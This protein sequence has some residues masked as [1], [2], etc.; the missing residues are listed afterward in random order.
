MSDTSDH[1]HTRYA[2]SPGARAGSGDAGTPTGR[3][4]L[5]SVDFD[6][7]AGFGDEAPAA[8]A[9]FIDL[10]QGADAAAA[11]AAVG[12]EDFLDL[13]GEAAAAHAA[14]E[15]IAAAAPPIAAAPPPPPAPDAAGGGGKLALIG[16]IV[17]A[18]VAAALWFALR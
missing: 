5:E 14:P 2:G 18:L 17:A 8:E 3:A 16:A 15:P 1:D 4:S 11:A 10:T 7:T 9:E 6:V 12:S 13:T